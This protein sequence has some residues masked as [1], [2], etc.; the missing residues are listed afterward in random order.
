VTNSSRIANRLDIAS[1]LPPPVD[2]EH[3]LNPYLS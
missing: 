3:V 2:Y 1:T